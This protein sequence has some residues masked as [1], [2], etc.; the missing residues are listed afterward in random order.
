LLRRSFGG[1]GGTMLKHWRDWIARFLPAEAAGIAGTYAGYLL[2]AEAGGSPLLS[3]YGAA[4]G[5]NCGYY[6]AVFGRDWFALP[7]DQRSAGRVVRAMIRDFGVA[8]VLDTLV[9]R[10]A[11][12]LGAVALFGQAIGIAVAKIA[13]DA[14][15]YLLAIIFWERRRTRESDQR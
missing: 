1:G 9:V 8:E 6:L 15:F 7:G 12:T 11:V 3:A 5:E 14:L 2:L 13:A 10:P 4:I